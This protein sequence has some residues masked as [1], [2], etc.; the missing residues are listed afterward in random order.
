MGLGTDLPPV[1]PIFPPFFGHFYFLGDLGG[2][3]RSGG[4]I[5]QKPT[6][7]DKGAVNPK[8][9]SRMPESEIPGSAS[10]CRLFGKISAAPCS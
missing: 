2:S 7:K 5:T 8:N 4:F 1:F 10:G 9:Y 6:N 3:N